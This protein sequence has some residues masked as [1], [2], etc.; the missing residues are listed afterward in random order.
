MGTTS[1]HGPFFY[2]VYPLLSFLSVFLSSW[3]SFAYPPSS[4]CDGF[5]PF[6]PIFLIFPEDLLLEKRPENKKGLWRSGKG[7]S[8]PS[9]PHLNSANES[10]TTQ[11]SGEA[12]MHLSC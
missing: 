6:P 8:S 5:P 4:I 2:H 3:I 10:S 11:V 1:Q 7:G 12:S 9:P